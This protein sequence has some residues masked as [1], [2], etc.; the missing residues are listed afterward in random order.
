MYTAQ[1][2]TVLFTHSLRLDQL[3]RSFQE[4]VQD[5]SRH[6]SPE[7]R[8]NY[9]DG[10]FYMV[11][12][13]E[14]LD[15]DPTPVSELEKFTRRFN[16]LHEVNNRDA[17]DEHVASYPYH[18]WVTHGES[19]DNYLGMLFMLHH[20]KANLSAELAKPRTLAIFVHD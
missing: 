11:V 13:F 16:R 8:L 18:A 14:M 12:P 4:F 5:W 20:L 9:F 1:A 15:A 7:E 10:E 2:H 19:I 6:A 17:L 3:P